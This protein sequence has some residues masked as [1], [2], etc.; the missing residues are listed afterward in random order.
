MADDVGGG[1]VAVKNMQADIRIQIEDSD[2]PLAVGDRVQGYYPSEDGG[3]GNFYGGKIDKLN[4]KDGTYFVVFDDG[5]EDDFHVWELRR[6][7]AAGTAVEAL[8]MGGRWQAGKVSW[9]RLM[10]TN[11]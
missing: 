5:D 8:A 10:P 7:L 9:M 2:R 4:L 1:I 11:Q 3:E 6:E